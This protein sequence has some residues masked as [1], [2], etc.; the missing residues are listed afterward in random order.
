M[1]KKVARLKADMAND[2]LIREI[3]EHQFKVKI[4]ILEENNQVLRRRLWVALATGIVLGFL[5][6]RS[7]GR[8]SPGC[9]P[10]CRRGE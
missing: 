10:C 7:S 9:A 5:A 6:G 2:L 8:G 3:N 4:R 1:G